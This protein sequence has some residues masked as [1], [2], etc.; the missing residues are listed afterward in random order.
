MEIKF[1]K[2]NWGWNCK[3]KIIYKNMSNK[4]NSDQIWMTKKLRG[5]KIEK[6]I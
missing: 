5:D 6:K 2:K 3:K 1:V 4:T